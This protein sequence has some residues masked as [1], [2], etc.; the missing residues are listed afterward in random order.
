M[1]EVWIGNSYLLVIPERYSITSSHS[2]G[3]RLELPVSISLTIFNKISLIIFNIINHKL[4][5]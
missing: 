5:H 1:F 2:S 3:L 4:P